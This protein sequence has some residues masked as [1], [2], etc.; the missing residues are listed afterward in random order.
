[1]RTRREEAAA[2]V[3]SPANTPQS[4]AT[5]PRRPAPRPPP[6]PPGQ[7]PPQSEVMRAITM[8]D[9][10]CGCMDCDAI[11]VGRQHERGSNKP[12]RDGSTLS[13]QPTCHLC[14][15]KAT[16]SA[17]SIQRADVWGNSTRN[18]RD[19]STLSDQ[20]TWH[21]F[22]CKATESAMSIQRA[23]KEHAAP[24]NN[25]CLVCRHAISLVLIRLPVRGHSAQPKRW[26]HRLPW[27]AGGAPISLIPAISLGVLTWPLA[28]S[29]IVS[30]IR[31]SVP[32]T[33]SS[34]GGKCLWRRREFDHFAAPHI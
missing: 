18:Q 20:P 11:A 23:A 30:G 4:R 25:P 21:L 8:E 12:K 19:G 6:R 13:D 14:G 24:K 16:E 33:I 27:R 26:V 17:M 5:S 1:M 34:V 32:P 31:I 22:G 15:C 28:A 7:W 2:A 10:P 9:S 29:S 3:N